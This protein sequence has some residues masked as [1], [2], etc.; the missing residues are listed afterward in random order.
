MIQLLGLLGVVGAIF[1][2]Y[3]AR[4]HVEEFI[5]VDVDEGL[6]H[7]ARGRIRRLRVRRPQLASADDVTQVLI[8]LRTARPSPSPT[9]S[10][11]A[12]S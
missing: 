8:E 1:A 5:R 3:Y 2:V 9:R 12:G 11:F 6:E 10:S 4:A 7:A